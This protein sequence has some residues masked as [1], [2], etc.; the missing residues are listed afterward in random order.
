MNDRQEQWRVIV[1]KQPQKALRRMPKNLRERIREIIWTL[2]ENPYPSGY[3]KLVG[4]KNNYRIR[5]GDWR[6]VYT[7]ENDQLLVLVIRIAPRGE[8]YQNL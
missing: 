8:A 3:K 7:I 1:M 5:V 4:F 6:I 2:A